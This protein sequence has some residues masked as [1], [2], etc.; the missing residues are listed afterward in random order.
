MVNP[1]RPSDGSVS[2]ADYRDRIDSL[3]RLFTGAYFLTL[4]GTLTSGWLTYIYVGAGARELNPVIV[5]LINLV[6]F[7]A[8]VLVRVVVVVVCFHAYSS[9]ATSFSPGLILAFA[10]LGAWVHLLDAA[11]DIGVVLGSGWFPT[12]RVGLATLLLVVSIVVGLW[13]RPPAVSR[14]A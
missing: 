9:L 10:W 11:H 3:G 7:E 14:T 12:G 6:G 8:M 4:V 2:V 5:A 1:H 13:F